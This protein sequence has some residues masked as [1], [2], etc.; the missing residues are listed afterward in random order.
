MIGH[1]IG[2]KKK[3]IE[4]IMRQDNKN[5]Q[6]NWKNSLEELS[7]DLAATRLE[8]RESGA[9]NYNRGR[10]ERRAAVDNL[11]GGNFVPRYSKLD[12]SRFDGSVDPLG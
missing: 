1:E 8:G 2:L 5:S 6:H 7:R 3:G 10:R 11:E 9:G 4:R 12:F